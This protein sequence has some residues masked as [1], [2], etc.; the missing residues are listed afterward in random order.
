LRRYAVRMKER[1]DELLPHA[2]APV[3]IHGDLTPWN[4]RYARGSLSAVLDFDAAHLDLRV[5]DFALSWRGQYEEVVRGYEEVW[6]LEPAERELIVP[7]YW[8]WVI[9]SAVAGLDAGATSTE[10]AVRH[11]LR[12]EHVR[13]GAA[14][15]GPIE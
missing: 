6:P 2:P 15:S 7:V 8:A 11:L 1:L 3:V 13:G 5:A 9:A 10:W 12:T 14:W 4:I